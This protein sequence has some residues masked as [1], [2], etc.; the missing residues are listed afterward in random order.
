MKTA[1]TEFSNA[2]ALNGRYI[3]ARLLNTSNV[4][5]T[6]DIV[7]LTIEESTCDTEG[8]KWGGVSSS[9]VEMDVKVSDISVFENEFI[10][11]FGLYVGSSYTYVT[12]GRYL[13]DSV[14]ME[15]GTAHVVAY[16]KM[17]K[18]QSLYVPPDTTNGHIF[19]ISS[20][21]SG[22]ATSLSVTV[23]YDSS[24][25]QTLAGNLTID[26][27]NTAITGYTKREML[28]MLSMCLGAFCYFGA[29]GYLHIARFGSGSTLNMTEDMVYERS[30]SS[31]L[32]EIDGLVVETDGGELRTTGSNAVLMNLYCPIMSQNIFNSISSLVA[33]INDYHA[34]S[35]TLQGNML[36][37]LRDK[38]S[39]VSTVSGSSATYV[40]YPHLIQHVYDGGLSTYVECYSRTDAESETDYKSPEIQRM[41]RMYA[42]IAAIKN[43]YANAISTDYL[44]A[45]YAK[46]NLANIETGSIKTAMIDDAQITSAKIGNAAVGTAQIQTGAITNAL[47]ATAA[48]DTA[49]LADAS[50]TDAKIV[51]LS[52]NRI[53]SGTL[54]TERLI[55]TG[56]NGSIVYALNNSGDLVSQSIDT[57]DGDV[58]TDRTITAD[59]IVASSITS[60]ELASNSVTANKIVAGAVTTDKIGANAVTAA[61]IDV[62]DLFSQNITFTGTLTG[63]SS[64]NGGIIKGADTTYTRSTETR[65]NNANNSTYS[66]V[67]YVT[68]NGMLLDLQNSCFAC[69]GLSIDS[70]GRSTFSGDIVWAYYSSSE[71]NGHMGRKDPGTCMRWTNVQTRNN[72]SSSVYDAAYVSIDKNLYNVHSNQ[73]VWTNDGDSLNMYVGA[74]SISLTAGINVNSPGSGDDM[75]GRG[76][77]YMSPTS[78]YFSRTVAESPSNANSPYNATVMTVGTDGDFVADRYVETNQGIRSHGESRFDASYGGG[79][80]YSDPLPNAVCAIKATGDI[81]T[82]GKVYSNQKECVVGTGVHELTNSG[83]VN[84]LLALD[85]NLT[86]SIHFG[87]VT[88]DIRCKKNVADT[89]VYATDYINRIDIKSFDWNYDR[90]DGSHVDAGFIAQQLE[91]VIPRAV[92]DVPQQDGSTLKNINH[93]ALIPYLVKALQEQ[94]ERIEKLEKRI[95]ELEKGE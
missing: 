1:T 43:L 82:T 25:I 20:L 87:D 56:S 30:I 6:A 86:G 33:D 75:I 55:L 27:V 85:N 39:Y 49:Q 57:I 72:V 59:K 69:S 76:D 79:S 66:A 23:V 91:E 28:S 14:N 42:E 21:I 63:G 92:Y 5:L 19:S 8:M 95:S 54:A 58:I 65:N 77:M 4:E 29:D 35:V 62:S 88:S 93:F 50:I 9:R 40:M 41:E 2:L 26:S 78:V 90:S 52:A 61:K 17:L 48:V 24:A 81:A 11:Q 13:A 67:H 34:G 84:L 16:D 68:S 70:D 53:T 46:I 45:N 47:I 74:G 73:G 71:D 36:L 80:D 10:V 12:M 18:A 60:N 89:K 94:N 51:S 37:D 7:S 38:I 83:N 22:I 3:T 15:G 64:G 32:T 31:A 44:D